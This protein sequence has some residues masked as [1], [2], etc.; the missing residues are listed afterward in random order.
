MGHLAGPS[1]Q[2][3][4]VPMTAAE[5]IRD[6]SRRGLNLSVRQGRLQVQAPSGLLDDDLRQQLRAHRDA[7]VAELSVREFANDG[8]RCTARGEANPCLPGGSENRGA[9][10]SAAPAQARPSTRSK[11][12]ELPRPQEP[13]EAIWGASPDRNAVVATLT[14]DQREAFDERAGLLEFDADL[15]RPEAEALALA[16]VLRANEAT[17]PP[18]SPPA[19]QPGAQA[20]LGAPGEHEGSTAPS[21]ASSVEEP[22]A[23]PPPLPTTATDVAR[24]DA[25]IDAILPQALAM[26]WRAA[27][28]LRTGHPSDL[29]TDSLGDL[30]DP[31]DVIVS[32][33]PRRI[34]VRIDATGPIQ[35][36]FNPANRPQPTERSR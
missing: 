19:A 15:P 35:F 18:V 11:D 17:T 16:E 28:L 34:G 13:T 7:L 20:D 31:G 30:L 25:A 21:R 4:E 26:G 12:S 8:A 9:S 5:L 36:V 3:G 22:A 33:S 6:A 10:A 23:Q 2:R 14:E 32:V 24:V 1:L 29:A 27:D